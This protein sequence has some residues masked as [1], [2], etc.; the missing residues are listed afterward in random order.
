MTRHASQMLGVAY[1]I[2]NSRRDAEDLL[3]DVFLEAWRKADSFDAQRGSVRGWLLL[4]VRSRAIDRVRALAVA[5]NHAMAEAAAD[6]AEQLTSDEPSRAPD[7]V[8]VCRALANLSEPQRQV[9]E[10][11]YFEGLTCREIAERCQI[12]I[13]TVKSPLVGRNGGAAW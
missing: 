6:C 5:R 9:L 11:G 7:R 3:H 8:R 2:L 4:R 1:R 13:G 12:P 10:L